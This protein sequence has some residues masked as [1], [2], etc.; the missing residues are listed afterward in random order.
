MRRLSTRI[1]LIPFTMIMLGVS[2][3]AGDV[4]TKTNVN[5]TEQAIGEH[6]ELPAAEQVAVDGV[7]YRPLDRKELSQVYNAMVDYLGAKLGYQNQVYTSSVRYTGED[8]EGFLASGDWQGE[9]LA[10]IY[11]NHDPFL[12]DDRELLS[13]VTDKGKL[14]S[15][16]GFDEDFRVMAVYDHFLPTGYVLNVIIFDRLNDITMQ[17]GRELLEDRMHLTPEGIGIV[18]VPENAEAALYEEGE[19]LSS[20][21]KQEVY[22]ML[23]Q[24]EFVDGVDLMGVDP[25]ERYILKDT[26]GHEWYIHTYPDG[27][28]GLTYLF[29]FDFYLK[30]ESNQNADMNSGEGEADADSVEFDYTSVPEINGLYMSALEQARTEQMNRSDLQ[31]NS[32]SAEGSFGGSPVTWYTW[33]QDGLEYHG[34]TYT[35][36]DEEDEVQPVTVVSG[37]IVNDGYDIG[38]S[39]IYVGMDEKEL[40][41]L[42]PEIYK[43]SLHVSDIEM[44]L[45]SQFPPQWTEQYDYGYFAWNGE[46]PDDELPELIVFLVSEGRV[47]AITICYPTAG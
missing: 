47:A 41:K 21:D 39:G 1:L 25:V 6:T 46:I 7:Y 13:E 17:Y 15:V 29:G 28:I 43:S 3:C 10:E 4:V 37:T 9:E 27:Y 12:A 45:R 23:L 42:Y 5:D 33:M 2:A 22:D 14:Y 44:V 11:I 34:V 36:D 19:E 30:A 35:I 40:V 18:Q 38:D 26:I 8:A 32:Y 20:A 24:A 16:P 31:E